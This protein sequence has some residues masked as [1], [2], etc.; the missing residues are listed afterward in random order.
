MVRNGVIEVKYL[1]R[2]TIN[3]V[4]SNKE[5][6]KQFL[7]VY[8]KIYKHSFSNSIL[9][10]N[11]KPNATMVANMRIWNEKVGRYIN[12]GTKAIKVLS[13]S[14]ES[15]EYLFDISDTTG[16]TIPKTWELNN[17]LNSDIIKALNDS[18][19]ID[20]KS[21]ETLIS[22]MVEIKVNEKLE[23]IFEELEDNQ[24]ELMS[25]FSQTLIESSKYITYKRCNLEIPENDIKFDFLNKFDTLKLKVVL[26]KSSCEISRDVLKEIEKEFLSIYKTKR[27][28]INYE[29]DS[30]PRE[31]RNTLS[32]DKDGN[33]GH[34]KVWENGNEISS[35]S[36][37]NQIRNATVRGS[38]NPNDERSKQTSYEQIGFTNR[39]NVGAR[40]NSRSTEY[41]RNI[42]T[43]TTTSD[44]SR[45]DSTEGD[46]IQNKIDNTDVELLN[47]SSIFIEK[48]EN[49]G[50]KT[51]FKNNILA[52]ETLKLL[53]KE[54]RL[55]NSEE[56]L[57]L[58]KY[59][60][61]GGMPQAFDE[62]SSWSD[63]NNQL[64]TLLNDEEYKSARASTP[65]AHYTPQVIVK[66]IYKALDNF[67][68]EQ[69]N[70]LEPSLGTGKF[71]EI[72]P[73][74]MRKNSNLYGVE[75]DDI[76]SRI[77]KKLYPF[78][79][80]ESKGYEET[81]YNNN[82]FDVAIGNIPF[83]DYKVFDRDFNKYNFYIHDYF[84]AKTLDK[85]RTGGVIAFVTSKGTLDK[86]ND[87]LRKYINERADLIGAIRLPSNAFKSA[88]T[89]VTTDII[90]LQ[91]REGLSK[92]NPNWLNVCRTEDDIPLNNYFIENPNMMLGKM[93]FD[94]K[95]F[96]ENSKYTKLINENEDFNLEEELFKAIS[97]LNLP[98]EF[99]REEE[100]YLEQLIED[101]AAINNK[102]EN[103][104]FG[105]K[106]D[107]IVYKENG[108]LN[109][110]FDVS[111]TKFDRAK[112]LVNLRDLTREVISIQANE[113]TEEELKSKQNI[114][115]DAYDKF[116]KKYGHLI[117][118]AN[119][120][121]FREDNY[122]PLLT[123]LEVEEKNGTI[124]K[125]DIFYKQTIKPSLKITSVD[126]AREGLTLSLIE[127]GKV[128]LNYIKTLYNKEFD[129]IIEELKGQIFLNPLEY[130]K[131]NILVGWETEDEYLSGN[132]REKLKIA[133]VHSEVNS[134][135]FA[136]NVEYLEKVQPIDLEASEISI[137]LGSTWIDEK[138]I[139]KFMY[140]TF[141]TPKFFR[142]LNDL[143][144]SA[145]SVN[146]NK[147]D[148]S[149]NVSNKSLDR[150]V[151]AT[152]TYGT[153]R[154]SAYTIIEESLNLRTVTVKDIVDDGDKTTYV[155]NQKET[156]LAR[157]KQTILKEEFKNWIFK[158]PERR[159]KYVKFYNETFNNIR[160]REF[161]GEYLSFP[162][163]NPGIKLRKHQKNAIARIIYGGNALLGHCVGAGKTFEMIAS[164]MEL[165]RLGIAKKSIMVVPNHLTEQFGADFL[166]LYPSA[167]VLV[168]TKKDF[169]KQNRKR[170]ISRIATGDY[171][172]IVIGHTQ[173][174]KIPISKERQEKMLNNQIDE[175]TTSIKTARS[176]KGQNW[177]IKQMEKFKKSLETELKSLL[178]SKKDD[179]VTFEELG[180]DY[181]FV[182]EAHY[183]KNCAV[184]SKINN[185]SGISNTKAKKSTDMLMKCQYIQEITGGR[186]VVFATGTP[187]SNSMT[188][189]Y[190]MQRYL[191]NNEL[192]KRGINHFDAWASNFGEIVSSLELAPEGT[193]YR[194]KSRFAKFTNLPELMN[195]FKSVADIQT[196]DM[197][198]L[199][200]PKL[201]NEKYRLISSEC[202]EFTKE[203]MKE[204]SERAEAIRSGKVK[205]NEDNMLKITN[206]AR[207]LGTDL[208]L[209]DPN[210]VSDVQSKVDKCVDSV[211]DEYIN[212]NDIKGTQIIFCDVGTPGKD[213]RFSIYTC[214]K[215]QLINKGISE[216]EICFI[217]DANN[218]TQ[219][220]KIFS[221][222][223]SGNKRIIIGSTQKMGTGTNIQD[224]LVALHHVDC[225]YRPSDIEQREGRILRQ[226]NMNAEVNIY[227]YVTKNTFDSY[228]WQIVEQK[229]KFISQVM[230][231][232]SI[233]RNCEDIDETVLSFAEV[234]AL[235]TGNPLI[236][237]KMN[238]DNDI[239]RLRVLK[240]SYDN[241]RYSLQDDF[242][243]KYPSLIKEET[244]K[245]DNIK[246]DIELLNKNKT[247]EFF[248]VVG[249]LNFTERE[250]CGTMLN[251]L[252][253][254]DR[255]NNVT[256]GKIY[257]FDLI[258]V[259][260]TKDIYIKANNK[261]TLELGRDAVGNLIRIENFLNNLGSLCNKKEKNI[262]VYKR[263]LEQ[264]KEE[265]AK[266]F[267]Y[268]YELKTKLA[269]QGELNMALDKDNVVVTDITEKE[270]IEKVKA[271]EKWIES[272]GSEGVQLN[273]EFKNLKGQRLLNLDLRKAKLK[274][275]DLTDCVI[276]ADLRGAD[277]REVN[278]NNT[279]FTGSNLENIV[280]E[281]NKLSEIEKDLL[282]NINRHKLGRENLKT[283]KEKNKVLER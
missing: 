164:C 213:G 179:M 258:S 283:N 271:H 102:I 49:T 218:E 87:F 236:K 39:T 269:R 119:K 105:I 227:R 111:S 110:I 150:S 156:M 209:I 214:I 37:T 16:R 208:R 29:R 216:D 178:E 77:A 106:D 266:P 259:G 141:D 264:A 174:E 234:K 204:F 273:L 270:V 170:F 194:I 5:E 2:D 125:A 252:L 94:N 175:I 242:T 118:K 281:V 78:A 138:D 186:G 145:I 201:K 167:N 14:L 27:K 182:D 80:I 263:N 223:R 257:G 10:Y 89:E 212:S 226:G 173:F 43:Q 18:Y 66:A 161:N 50:L 279:K 265:Y 277:L 144:S 203:K 93:V 82:F 171:D 21:M 205:P 59:V 137:R 220:E 121:I 79:K 278:I 139:E 260:T 152:K 71:F 99:N 55:P 143:D 19:E 113:C 96:G 116:V 133:K 17:D 132:V 246:K 108:V 11:Q 275:A 104:T 74:E 120:S 81:N 57:N 38:I 233:A 215:E 149:W 162:G 238:I 73:N 8:S 272:N 58:L 56:R 235:A 189:L 165:K 83:G 128:D 153:N 67:G 26:G 247:K 206:E 35:R 48:N 231:S 124:K 183:Y 23:E 60:G 15:V 245:R 95:M 47:N 159:N 239:A 169:E 101:D 160:L 20:S 256:I 168:T 134:G 207:L 151:L 221:D 114:L 92:D 86:E 24:Q 126:T 163:M 54:N 224:R 98:N 243:F 219:R 69:G 140:E 13:D 251:A 268:E 192:K 107:K 262:E 274:G 123:S 45:G 6:W 129:E 154:M 100:L 147:L 25:V 135:I 222:M 217:H 146:F 157:E 229:Q 202:S 42:Q 199:P 62:R 76:S 185:V 196:P 84:F 255:G 90:F 3:K 180:V 1:Y 31:R 158:D 250:P 109:E 155:V 75:L 244:K 46:S 187:I 117:D 142:N 91:K 280:I 193:G 276:Y 188:E 190:V 177:S 130:D 52:I 181:M 267:I 166:R 9:I 184:F 65:N 30:I 12:K 103:Y 36:E 228:L 122:Y 191:Q 85:V 248:A 200:V 41:N 4:T 131:D 97:I 282:E 63:E 210:A 232:K 68:I 225:P 70:I 172:A 127:K 237:E 72:M 32:R 40:S 7:D 211:F 112:S 61:W 34:R 44:D 53:E 197:L 28:E 148:S 261:Y 22:N 176:E 136:C 253:E 198:K 240:T 33:R 115:N 254:K 88:N 64:K 241:Q 230:T 249:G 51:K 195:I